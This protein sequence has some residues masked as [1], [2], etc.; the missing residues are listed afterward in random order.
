VP[1][2]I[3]SDKGTQ[4]LSATWAALCN[5][6][7]INHITTT[8]YHPQSNGMVE[9]VHR[10]LKDA[11]RARRA[12]P[13]WPDHLPWVLL[14]LRAAP[15]EDAAV[16]SAELVLGSPLH[17]PG[18]LA[19]EKETP[20]PQVA[21]RLSRVQPPPT[22]PLTYAQAAASAPNLL[23]AAD[24]VYIRRG[25][26]VPPLQPLY[27]GPYRV[28][29]KA[30]KFFKLQ[31]GGRTEVVSVDRLKPHRGLAP[32]EPASPPVRGRPPKLATG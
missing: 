18:Q 21:A 27:L 7:G 23:D 15:K 2:T 26:V 3:T 13:L 25:G 12:G 11:L 5:R 4:F 22:R 16:S 10:Q 32:V 9:R 8:S 17:L 20:L 19:T 6:L 28:L 24:Y 31:I 30:R 29:E 1:D 14:G